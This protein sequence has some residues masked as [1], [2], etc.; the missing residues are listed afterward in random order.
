M[1]GSRIVVGVD[2]SEP[3]LKALRWAARQAKLTGSTVHAVIAW[4][5]PHSSWGGMALS[6]GDNPKETAEK[7]LE[8]AVAKALPAEAA[9]T[10]ERHTGEGHAAQV[11]LDHAEGSSLLVVGDRGHSTF[12]ATLMG[13]TSLQVTQHAKRPVVVVRGE[14]VEDQD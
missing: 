5:L 7:V 13:S 3:S 11:L 2:G 9:A 4:E 8:E 6:A 10:V 12:G 1:S 14:V